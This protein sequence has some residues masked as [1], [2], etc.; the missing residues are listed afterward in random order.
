M[1]K[2]LDERSVPEFSTI[3]LDDIFL[4]FFR[5]TVS[6]KELKKKNEFRVTKYINFF[7]LIVEEFF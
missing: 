6:R 3:R 4:I 7:S 2:C 1:M 5:R